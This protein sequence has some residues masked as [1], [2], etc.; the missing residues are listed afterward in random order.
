MAKEAEV[1]KKTEATPARA[2]S[3]P[4]FT[5]QVDIVETPDALVVYADMPGVARDDVDVMLEKGVLSI[6]GEAGRADEAGMEGVVREYDVG[7]FYR[8]FTVAQGLDAESVEGTIK[9]GVLRLEIPKSERYKPRR[10]EI[11]GE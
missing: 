4:M 3:G 2:Y 8:S 9:D 6:A 10:I 11:K 5:P 1:V 7:H